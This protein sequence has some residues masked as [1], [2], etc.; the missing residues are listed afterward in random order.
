MPFSL[1][2]DKS[3]ARI[4]TV[5]PELLYRHLEK[6]FGEK[7]VMRYFER[8]ICGEELLRIKNWSVTEPER[9]IM[10]AALIGQSADITFGK[11]IEDGNVKLRSA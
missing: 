7:L 9:Y 6:R 3:I 8:R 2:Y 1:L 11:K 10:L 5:E 4:I